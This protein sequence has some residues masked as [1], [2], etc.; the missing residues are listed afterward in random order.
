[1]KTQ[2]KMS[3]SKEQLDSEGTA[4]RV[5]N[6]LFLEGILGQGA[7]GTVRLARRVRPCENSFHESSPAFNTDEFCLAAV[8]RSL[9]PPP[10][11]T[12]LTN[13]VVSVKQTD[14]L[15]R[16]RISRS[17]SAPASDDFF[18][19]NETEEIIYGKKPRSKSRALRHRHRDDAQED[20]LVAVKI[21][22]KSILKRIRT[23]ERN[24]Q[25]R[26]VQVRTALEKVEREIAIMKKL[27]H[28]NLV[29]FFEAI[30]SPDSDLLYMVI[31]YM[32]LGEIL[33]Y[34]KGGTFRRDDDLDGLINGHFDEHHSSLYFVDILHG[35]A[36]LHQHHIIHRDIKP[37]NVLLDARG[38]AK[39]S[40]FGVSHIFDDSDTDLERPRRSSN[41][42]CLT[43]HDTDTAL[44]MKG[45]PKSGLIT[46]TEGT[47]AFW[48]PEM[49]QG[50]KA[51]SGYAA[52]LWAAGVC[53]YIFVSGKLPFYSDVPLE[54]MDMIKIG[55]V[56]YEGLQM[57]EGLLELLYM[58][59]E[60]DP[61]L[62]AG[63]GDCLKHPALLLARAQRV[64]QLS[65]ELERSKTTR[66]E[67]GEQDLHSVRI[68]VNLLLLLFK[69]SNIL[70]RR[71]FVLLQ[72][73]HLFYS[74]R[75]QSS[76]KKGFRLLSSACLQTQSV[77]L[78]PFPTGALGDLVLALPA[79]AQPIPVFTVSFK[80]VT[81]SRNMLLKSTR[82]CARAFRDSLTLELLAPALKATYHQVQHHQHPQ[83]TVMCLGLESG[84]RMFA[85]TVMMGAR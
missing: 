66:I 36:Y 22:Q 24:Q 29:C 82:L 39:L 26:Q 50:G 77:V 15:K 72:H 57:S 81:L 40:D 25:T 7:Y 71:R 16:T 27:S 6:L 23:M 76:S 53:L 37:Q 14:P 12:L 9:S 10:E 73:C 33:T 67:V 78:H 11:S 18:K 21:F 51:F 28:P 75:Q 64:Q 61:V 54:L 13:T 74:N 34:C 85:R 70:A 58:T 32:P 20:E 59:L 83:G 49:C 5:A 17:V 31:E 42:Q 84:N 45:M 48:S 44:S 80:K 79:Q 68:V 1:M 30:D 43:R 2:Q 35:L 69:R 63:V 4:L 46:K 56:S 8:G 55:N 19:L 3:D 60:R 52:D 62:R 38:I 41:P 65:I 47:W